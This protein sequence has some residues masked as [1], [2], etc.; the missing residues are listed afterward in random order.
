MKRTS[1]LVLLLVS[2]AL[3]LAGC[4]SEISR[5]QAILSAQS[6]VDER[7]KFYVDDPLTNRTV[8]QR[9]SIKLI[10]ATLF[11]GEWSIVMNVTSNATGQDKG[12]GMIVVVDAKSGEV[13]PDKTVSFKPSQQENVS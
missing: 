10:D 2:S 5:E 4:G 7:V 13:K 1:I 3:L 9:A 8:V 12:S 11:R 6:F